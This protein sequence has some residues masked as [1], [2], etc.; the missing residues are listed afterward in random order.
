[1]KRFKDTEKN[2]SSAVDFKKRNFLKLVWI[3]WWASILWFELWQ[4]YQNHWIL[5]QQEGSLA[6]TSNHFESRL[7]NLNGNFVHNTH[8][9][10]IATENYLDSGDIGKLKHE[11]EDL[12]IHD[13]S[14]YHARIIDF[15]WNE[16]IRANSINDR[17]RAKIVDDSLLQKKANRDYFIEAKKA[18]LKE[19]ELFL[20][21]ISLN[22]DHWLVSKIPVIRFIER[23]YKNWEATNYFVVINY[24]PPTDELAKTFQNTSTNFLL[25][26]KNNTIISSNQE[27]YIGNR[28]NRSELNNDNFLVTKLGLSLWGTELDNSL[29][30]KV[31]DST[32]NS[33]SF[34]FWQWEYIYIA[35][36][37]KSTLWILQWLIWAWI[38]SA[39]SCWWLTILKRKTNIERQKSAWRIL[40]FFEN[41]ESMQFVT[42]ADWIIS[43][44]NKKVTELLGFA[45][46]DK[47]EAKINDIIK[48][49]T[50]Y[51]NVLKQDIDYIEY[52]DWSLIPVRRRE[53]LSNG[54]I[55]HTIVDISSKIKKEIEQTKRNVLIKLERDLLAVAVS[56][57]YN[58]KQKLHE[59]LKVLLRV[60]WLW[61]QAKWSIF[62]KIVWD[63]I[64][65][66]TQIDL[67]PDLISLCD[68]VGCWQCLCGLVAE[69]WEVVDS[70][71]IDHRHTILPGGVDLKNPGKDDHWHYCVPIMWKL[72]LLWVLNLY[73][74]VWSHI[75]EDEKKVIDTA[76]SIIANVM[77]SS[78][79]NKTLLRKQL[80]VSLDPR[81]A[82]ICTKQ[83]SEFWPKSMVMS[84][85]HSSLEIIGKL[86]DDKWIESEVLPDG[87]DI[88]DIEKSK[89]DHSYEKQ[90]WDEWFLFII[91]WVK[92]LDCAIIY[93]TN[94]TNQKR[95]EE[96]LADSH[97]ATEFILEEAPSPIITFDYDVFDNKTHKHLKRKNL[98]EKIWWVLSVRRAN[99]KVLEMLGFE[100]DEFIWL[101]ILNPKIIDDENAKL[102]YSE[103]IWNK[104]KWSFS[105]QLDLKHK[106]WSSFPVRVELKNIKDKNSGKVRTLA[107]LMD[108][109]ALQEALYRA[110]HDD[111][112]DLPNRFLVDTKL[113]DVIEET[114]RS[115]GKLWLLYM[116]LN[117]LTWINGQY[118][119]IEADEVLRKVADVMKKHFRK[120]DTVW[121]YW[122]DEFVAIMKNINNPKEI[123]EKITAILEEFKDGLV[124]D[125][126]TVV[127]IRMSIWYDIYN[128]KQEDKNSNR[129]A[130]AKQIKKNADAAMYSA[131]VKWK[132]KKLVKNKYP[133][134]AQVRRSQSAFKRFEDN[135]KWDP[136]KQ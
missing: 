118:W 56:F 13:R 14:I 73:K 134:E 27:S 15:E 130:I 45:L 88:N 37:E 24:H 89:T 132:W 111:L 81:P 120:S 4:I 71:S 109:K 60:P 16:V 87:F 70:D 75:D 6:T 104:D 12:I 121:R 114:N 31:S 135:M 11:F 117:F 36:R 3:Y 55:L 116:D 28:F 64:K 35:Q 76:V 40:W 41:F 46:K 90:I 125:D 57:E 103:M 97:S 67:H 50:K 29:K 105:C 7:T 23:V 8:L 128:W 113:D 63:K 136:E 86:P 106:N 98:Y 39:L 85:N 52:P 95:A 66:V 62:E 17:V 54:L 79:K 93:W 101:D 127:P 20:S 51:N 99:K 9:A 78:I 47:K 34:V 82:F 59:I 19:W 69:T 48:I 65:M 133:R 26:N 122:W 18:N 44:S 115:E 22:Q 53:V 123:E 42:N 110:T 74:D 77:T 61:V 102:L 129:S 58:Y 108:E 84:H 119:H 124:L 96:S 112:T 43:Y 92:E 91:K 94:I 131:K 68:E 33:K 100:K 21:H 126:W 32:W 10:K 49:V 72:W 83:E 25:V 2:N 107:T 30:L 1:M 80:L 38:A 5:N